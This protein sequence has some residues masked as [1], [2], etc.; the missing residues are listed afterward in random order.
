MVDTSRR[1]FLRG[2]IAQPPQA[3]PGTPLVVQAQPHCLAERGVECRVCGD[4]CDTRALR[5]V[6]RRGGVA[7]LRVDTA[8]CTGCGDCVG[9]C[10]VAALSLVSPA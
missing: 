10:P 7:Q 2:R 1:L 3:A 6:P 8:A 9:A 4:N 5:F